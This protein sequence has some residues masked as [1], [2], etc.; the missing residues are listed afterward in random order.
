MNEKSPRAQIATK[1]KSVS[2]IL[3][4]VSRNPNVDQLAAALGLT[5]MLDKLGKHATAV[6]SGKIPPAINFL[7]PEKTFE[8]NADSLRDFII[9][10]D[11]DKADRLRFKTEGDMVRVY[12]TPYKTTISEK[13]L[14]FSEGDF[15]VELVVAIGV[16]KRDELDEAIAAHGRILHSATVATLN[17]DNDKDALG[18]I[19]WGDAKASSYSELIADL[20]D[21]IS[22]KQTLMDDQVATALLTGVVAATDQFRNDKTTPSTMTLAANLMAKGAN[23][24]LISS[25]L[26]SAENNVEPVQSHATST[27]EATID[28]QSDKPVETEFELDRSG[29]NEEKPDNANSRDEVGDVKPPMIDASPVLQT[30]KIEVPPEVQ[31]ADSA[32]AGSTGDSLRDES[33]RLAEARSQ[34]ALAAAQAELDSIHP[35][36]T[37]IPTPPSEQI[38]ASEAQISP[39]QSTDLA[40]P[41]IIDNPVQPQVPESLPVDAI[42]PVVTA[43]PPETSNNDQSIVPPAINDEADK[44]LESQLD[45][46]VKSNRENSK[47]AH[48]ADLNSPSFSHGTPYVGGV[49]GAPLSSAMLNDEQP[50]SDSL[51]SASPFEHEPQHEQIVQPPVFGSDQSN[52]KP[53]A[54]ALTG[55][56]VGNED[57]LA[58]AIAAANSTES[59]SSQISQSKLAATQ[60]FGLPMPPT[61][62]TPDL[63]ALPPAFSQTSSA[64]SGLPPVPT[65]VPDFS[66]TNITERPASPIIPATHSNAV[67]DPTQYQIPT[68]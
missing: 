21:D 31:P 12:I 27:D 19:S 39:S 37:P 45:S 46:L 30:N 8:D 62:P 53:P 10:L 14:S 43:I 34:D 28:L 4:T 58:A 64:D 17:I 65:A 35:A 66:S 67:Y 61:P 18:S 52:A 6:F 29:D 16:D 50:L 60:D 63:G 11:K 24:Q 36:S 15:N 38:P 59:S 68:R 47:V 26:S 25:E 41:P 44:D 1:I 2:N 23:Q 48:V 33:S 7:Q 5:F 32:V 55:L 40:Q 42:Q 20:S 56:P 51:S 22:D 54:E 13:D 57:A 3:V 9:S 49:M